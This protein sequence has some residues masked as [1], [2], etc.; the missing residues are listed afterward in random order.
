MFTILISECTFFCVL[1]K[2]SMATAIF[3]LVLLEQQ[4]TC[5]KCVHRCVSLSKVSSIIWT[6]S[7]YF[8]SLLT[9][10][11][12][13]KASRLP[14]TIGISFAA[15]VLCA[16]VMVVVLYKKR[17]RHVQRTQETDGNYSC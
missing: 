6:Y 1:L 15:L 3:V 13:L 8:N 7:T 10:V 2:Y 9:V 16:V 5:P 4:T 14:L 17:Q 11:F 12:L